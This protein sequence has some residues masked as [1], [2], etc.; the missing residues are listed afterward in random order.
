MF[1]RMIRCSSN[2]S[3]ALRHSGAILVS[4]GSSVHAL[5]RFR[6]DCTIYPS[7]S[8]VLIAALMSLRF[9]HNS[10]R[11]LVSFLILIPMRIRAVERWESAFG[12]PIFH[13]SPWAAGM[14]ESQQRF[15]RA[16]GNDEKPVLVFL[17]FHGPAFPQPSWS[18]ALRFS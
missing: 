2:C 9:V 17:V 16:V 8:R 6:G 10:A 7:L 3:T 18:Y 14:W 1:V 13:R 4:E 11:V 5:C 12:F 15:P